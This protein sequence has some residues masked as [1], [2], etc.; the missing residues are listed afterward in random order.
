MKLSRRKKAVFSL[1]AFGLVWGTAECTLRLFGFERNTTVETMKF[2]FRF[3]EL[4]ANTAVP[5][6]ER[7]DRLFWKPRAFVLGHNSR[8]L[9]GP[10]FSL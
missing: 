7:D 6:L 3:D 9:V 8:G 1:I 5:L 10:E 2:T 4:N